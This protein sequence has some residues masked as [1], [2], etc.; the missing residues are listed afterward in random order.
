MP[1]G[2]HAPLPS[3]F[4]SRKYFAVG[5]VALVIH[6]QAADAAAGGFDDIQE[7]LAGIHADLVG[8]AEALGHD[9]EFAVLVARDVAVLEVGA[10]GVHPVLDLGGNGDPDAVLGIAQDEV[11]LADGLAVNAV[12]QHLGGAV[13]GHDFEAVGAEI[14]DQEI[15]VAGEC[16]TVRERALKV[17]RSLA[18]HLLEMPRPLLRD[19]LLRAVGP[20]PGDAAARVGGPEGAVA[21]GEDA[22][23]PLQIMADVLEG[24]LV[25]FEVLDG[26]GGHKVSMT[27]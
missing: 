18:G 4:G 23:G 5:E 14:R 3:V 13:A 8:E 17:T 24:R 7:L 25:D 21:F 12:G 27:G 11:H 26:V 10:E 6:A 22:F 19:D 1:S 9:A 2:F 15:A 16:Q 20:E